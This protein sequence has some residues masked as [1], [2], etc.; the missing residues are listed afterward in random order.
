MAGGR[1]GAWA[2]DVAERG[3]L[4]PG[5]VEEGLRA[6]ASVGDDRIQRATT[7]RLDPL[8]TDTEPAGLMLPPGPAVAVM[9][10]V[11]CCPVVKLQE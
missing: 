8:L 7:G 2:R 6:A 1:A 9:V 11:G 10:K 3:R 4:D 5:D